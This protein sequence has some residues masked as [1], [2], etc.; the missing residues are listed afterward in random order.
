MKI[1]E[2]EVMYKL[3]LGE[4]VRQL[5]TWKEVQELYRQLSALIAEKERV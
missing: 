4:G 5:L 1:Y 3:E 2:C